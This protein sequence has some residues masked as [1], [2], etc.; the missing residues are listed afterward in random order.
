M[1]R[2]VY[3][4][5]L[6]AAGVAALLAA[7]VSPLAAQE[8][9]QSSSIGLRLGAGNNYQRAEVAWESPSVWEYRFEGGSRLD[10]V[11]ELGVAY[12]HANGS[13]TPSSVWQLSAIPFLRWT[14]ADRYYIEAGI[15]ATVFSRTRFANKDMSTA[16]QFGDHIGVGMHVTNNSRVSLRYSHFSNAGIKRP[17]PGLDILQLNYSYQY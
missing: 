14:W 15:G 3:R 10:L 16:F 6:K 17:N 5:V 9:Y 7:A 11:G 13:R 8:L 4:Q 2:K 12:W 1:S